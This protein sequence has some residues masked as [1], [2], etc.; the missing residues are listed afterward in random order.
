[1]SRSL[2]LRPDDPDSTKSPLPVRRMTSSWPA[3]LGP[4]TPPVL[5][6]R[7]INSICRRHLRR[8]LFTATTEPRYFFCASHDSPRFLLPEDVP[9]FPLV[10]WNSLPVIGTFFLLSHA[11]RRTLSRSLPFLWERNT[12]PEGRND[13]RRFSLPIADSYLAPLDCV[14]SFCVTTTA[15]VHPSSVNALWLH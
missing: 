11:W 12:L 10:F 9:L 8:R 14:F 3:F 1:M 4:R 5:L 15:L 6:S 13:K 7:R 2:V